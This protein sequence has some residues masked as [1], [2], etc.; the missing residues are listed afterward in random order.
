MNEFGHATSYEIAVLN[1][2]G[3]FLKL[4]EWD[5]VIGGQD[6]LVVEHVLAKVDCGH[7]EELELAY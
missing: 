1:S 2:D 3:E 5:D 6:W 4:S 7:A